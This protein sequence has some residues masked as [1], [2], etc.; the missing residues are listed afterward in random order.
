MWTK[1]LQICHSAKCHGCGAQQAPMAVINA[2]ECSTCSQTFLR[3]QPPGERKWYQLIRDTHQMEHWTT[4]ACFSEEITSI[5]DCFG[6]T[7]IKI[8]IFCREEK[9]RRITYAQLV[10]ISDSWCVCVFVFV[11]FLCMYRHTSWK[12][13]SLSRNVRFQQYI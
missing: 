9:S 2:E 11:T 1:Y 12:N 8:R 6:Q 5:K 13:S 7:P 3:P 4:L 10:K